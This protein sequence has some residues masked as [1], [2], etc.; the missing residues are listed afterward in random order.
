MHAKL[1]KIFEHLWGIWRY[2]WTALSIAWVLAMAGWVAVGLM[3]HR[4]EAKARLFVDTNEVLD[5]LIEDIAVKQD[6][7]SRISLISRT[8]RSRPNL[9]KLVELTGLDRDVKNNRERELLIGGLEKEI[10][11]YDGVGNQAFYTV[12]YAHVDPA[13]ALSVVETMIDLFVNSTIGDD[14]EHNNTTQTLLDKQIS[15]Y[16]MRLGE[17]EQRLSAFKKKHAGAMP[18]EAGGYYQRLETANSGLRTAALELREAENRQAVLARQIRNERPTIRTG[19]VSTGGVI[20]SRIDALQDKLDALL[21]RYTDKHPQVSLL[22]ESIASLQADKAA[23]MASGATVAR[24]GGKIEANKVYQEM[25]TMLTESEARVAE[26]QVR[27]EN[28]TGQVKEL[29]DT[30]DSIPEVE[31]QLAQ[32]DRDYETVRGKYQ[33]LLGKRESARLTQ[34]VD[35]SSADVKFKVVDPPYVPS[36]PTIPDKRLLSAAVLLGSLAAGAGIAL[37]LSLIRPVFYTRRMLAAATD[38]PVL[39]TVMLMETPEEL[40]AKKFNFTLFSLLALGLFLMFL[41]VMFM[42]IMNIN[43]AEFGVVKQLGIVDVLKDT[44]AAADAAAN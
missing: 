13:M 17:S 31:A 20:E 4:F 15:S 24:S 2:R 34:Q 39:G 41:L 29:T 28:Y 23:M 12:T 32:L 21:V 19:T 8:M 3:Q 43:P 33:E 18:G 25:R 36:R 6:I 22:K 35:I 38:L 16:E 40:S 11:I 30:V 1:D 26:L 27:V 37:L 7:K 9:E 5:G 44:S 10:A 42:Q 14:L